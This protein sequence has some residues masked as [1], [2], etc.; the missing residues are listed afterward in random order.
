MPT[1]APPV[2]AERALADRAG[3]AQWL[4]QLG[5]LLAPLRPDRLVV[6]GGLV[7]PMKLQWVDRLP[8]D[9][10]PLQPVEP[11]PVGQSGWLIQL[12]AD[13]SDP[14]LLFV[15]ARARVETS[16]TALKVVATLVRSAWRLRQGLDDE[17]APDDL[18]EAI[19]ALRNSLNSVLMSAA[20]VT[21]CADLLPERLQPIAREIEAA[22]ARSVQR[23]HRL[24][25]LIESGY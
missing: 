12:E 20:V 25:G 13:E 15:A 21:T 3:L 1:W 23:L 9:V 11:S 4:G 24:T 16:D 10:Q 6:V 2:L 5:V 19:H 7:L 17:D 22:A 14:L 8:G 18:S